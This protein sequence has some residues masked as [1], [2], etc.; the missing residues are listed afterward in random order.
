M[1]ITFSTKKGKFLLITVSPDAYRPTIITN[2]K[3]TNRY[4]RLEWSEKSTGVEHWER[5]D[6]VEHWTIVGL[7]SSIT[8]EQ[9]AEVVEA[10]VNAS[11]GNVDYYEN[12]N[13]PGLSNSFKSAIDSLKSLIDT[14]GLLDGV[15]CIILKLD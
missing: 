8:E 3:L 9:A 13:N 12:Y 6:W 4:G 2:K 10:Y 11:N 5:L 1:N 7:V 15:N 14:L